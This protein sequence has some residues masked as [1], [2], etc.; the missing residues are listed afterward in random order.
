MKHVREVAIMQSISKKNVAIIITAVMLYALI[1]ATIAL[2]IDK[3]Q[4]NPNPISAGSLSVW[5]VIGII[6]SLYTLTTPWRW[7]KRLDSLLNKP[8]MSAR[9]IWGNLILFCIIPFIAPLLYGLV[10]FFMGM[11]IAEFCFFIALSI[12]G[13]LLW[14]Q[15]NL[16]MS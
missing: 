4:I 11:S 16:R 2:A 13:V 9:R 8:K 3:L 12:A 15:Y 5:K 14:A 6:L 10:L 1:F 7:R